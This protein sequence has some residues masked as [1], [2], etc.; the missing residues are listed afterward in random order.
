MI[1]D[2]EPG[3]VWEALQADPQAQLCDVRTDAEWNFVGIPDLQSLGREV[4][5]IPWQVYPTMQRNGGFVEHLREAGMVSETPIYFL[6]RSG[7]RSLAAAQA[8]Q[9]AGFTR[10]YNVADGFEGPPDGQGHRGQVSGWKA[11]GL[12]WHQ[13]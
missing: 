9:A 3:K 5:L 6:C 11:E 12:P 7:A 1:E 8:A 13:R 4:V 10:V 2:I